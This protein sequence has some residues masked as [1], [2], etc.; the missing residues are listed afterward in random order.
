LVRGDSEWS[1]RSRLYRPAAGDFVVVESGPTRVL[2][3][4]GGRT[5]AV[6]HYRLAGIGFSPALSRWGGIRS[7]EYALNR[8]VILDFESQVLHESIIT[9]AAYDA[10]RVF[11]AGRWMD[12][13]GTSPRGDVVRV[14]VDLAGPAVRTAP[15]PL[16]WQHRTASPN[17]LYV[18]AK[19]GARLT[20][21]RD[22]H[23]DLMPAV[24]WARDEFAAIQDETV[25]DDGMVAY[26]GTERRARGEPALHLVCVAPDGREQSMAS[27]LPEDD[28]PRPGLQFTDRWLIEGLRAPLEPATDRIIVLH[29]LQT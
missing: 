7:D 11:G 27:P 6:L 15:V 8:V 28:T 17:G 19:Y 3:W 22:T 12:W 24:V 5:R 10:A 2:S 20:L 13:V 9:K 26:H 21:Y 29:D 23:P 1:A 25:R 4:P 18:L 16:G 14:V